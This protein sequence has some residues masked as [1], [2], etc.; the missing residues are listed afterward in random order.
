MNDNRNIEIA[1]ASLDSERNLE[2]PDDRQTHSDRVFATLENAIVSGEIALGERI[3]EV[4]LAQRLGVSRGPMREALRRLEGQGL[5]TRLPH[6]GVR[7]TAL[8]KT[9]LIELYEMRGVLEGLAC[10]LAADRIT[11]S[12]LDTLRRI[13]DKQRVEDPIEAVSDQFLSSG[14]LDFHYLIAKGAKSPRLTQVLCRDLYSL[15]RL[16]RFRTGHSPGRALKA[17]QDHENILNA[18]HQRDGEL[19]ELLMRRHI[20][21]AQERLLSVDEF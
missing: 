17:F 10:R 13:V 2:K 8:T 19:A 11:T 9:E 21:S 7:V 18:L 20:A 5:V 15:I 12:E 14:D 3:A 16:F 1:S 4:A 6:A